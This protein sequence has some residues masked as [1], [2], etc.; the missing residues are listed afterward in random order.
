[1]RR[2][3]AQAL[4]RKTYPK[5]HILKGCASGSTNELPSK[6]KRPEADP[7]LRPLSPQQENKESLM[8]EWLMNEWLKPQIQESEV[9]MEV[10]SYLPA[11]LERA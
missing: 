10:T 2:L 3:R 5:S 8:N 1:L 4:F 11:E 6:Q 7:E 9:G